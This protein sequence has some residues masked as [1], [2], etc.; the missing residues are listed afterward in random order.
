MP[1]HFLRLPALATESADAIIDQD[2]YA[3]RLI[4]DLDD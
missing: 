2:R 1:G 3:L 4:A